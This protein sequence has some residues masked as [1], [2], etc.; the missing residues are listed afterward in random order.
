[1]KSYKGEDG[2][3]PLG[4]SDSTLTTNYEKEGME[5]TEGVRT[6]GGTWE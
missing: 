4:V 1:M 3:L 2:R 5:T 6:E